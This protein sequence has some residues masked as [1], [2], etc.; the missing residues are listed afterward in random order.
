MCVP[1]TKSIQTIPAS[2]PGSA[3]MMMNGSSQLWKFTTISAYT[4]TIENSSPNTSPWNELRIVS[5]WPRT[6]ICVP[7]GS[8]CLHREIFSICAGD[9]GQVRAF[10]RAIDVD[11]RPRVVVAYRAL[12]RAALNRREVAENLRRCANR[13]VATGKF[14]SCCRSL[15]SYCGVCTAML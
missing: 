10:D 2:A 13:C 4:S 15:T 9:A 14:S 8:F 6:K 11:D 7:R 5:T 1:V 12:L 3:A